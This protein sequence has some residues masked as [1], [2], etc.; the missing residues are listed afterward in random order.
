MVTVPPVPP[1]L[2]LEEGYV[3]VSI[4]KKRLPC[5]N[6]DTPLGTFLHR[7]CIA[8][9]AVGRNQE[10]GQIHAGQRQFLAENGSYQTQV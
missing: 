3:R 5:R 4:G 10:P 2:K 1:Q 6:W 9:W 8:Q 7:P